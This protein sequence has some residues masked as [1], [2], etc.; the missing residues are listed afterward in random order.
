MPPHVFLGIVPTSSSKDIT[1][2]PFANPSLNLKPANT[3]EQMRAK[4]MSTREMTKLHRFGI[5]LNYLRVHLLSYQSNGYLSPPITSYSPRPLVSLPCAHPALRVSSPS[6]LQGIL[7]HMSFPS[8]A[9]LLAGEHQ[10]GHNPRGNSK[11]LRRRSLHNALRPLPETPDPLKLVEPEAMFGGNVD[12]I[13]KTGHKLSDNRSS[14]KPVRLH[15]MVKQ[16]WKS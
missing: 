4:L 1:Y 11:K 9:F 15:A 10:S 3:N 2:A 5:I 13:P 7:N 16:T 6:I 8:G 14:L 12:T